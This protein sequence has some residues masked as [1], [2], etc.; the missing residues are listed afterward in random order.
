MTVES[1]GSRFAFLVWQPP[2]NSLQNGLIRHYAVHLMDGNTHITIANTTSST[3][4]PE[5]NIGFLQPNTTYACLVAAV[6]ISQGP[7]SQELLFTTDTDG[8]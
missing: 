7:Y 1:I 2:Q 5:I 4:K 3:S 6:T 8:K